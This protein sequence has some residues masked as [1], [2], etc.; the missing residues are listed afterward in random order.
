MKGKKL[1]ATEEWLQ[2]ITQLT[3]NYRRHQNSAVNAEG[4]KIIDR[5]DVIVT[6][7]NSHHIKQGNPLF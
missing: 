6:P 1:N 4:G 2:A 3:L 7:I 5:V